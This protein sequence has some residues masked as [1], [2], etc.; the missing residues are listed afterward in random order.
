MV[1]PDFRPEVEIQ[2]FLAYAMKNTQYNPYLWQNC[3]NFRVPKE[4]GAEKH[5]GDVRF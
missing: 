5:D 1:T 2:P 3:R 4:I